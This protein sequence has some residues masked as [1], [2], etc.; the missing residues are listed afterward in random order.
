MLP[1]EQQSAVMIAALVHWPALLFT[2]AG[3]QPF[4]CSMG[5][6]TAAL[7]NSRVYAL[8]PNALQA[9]CKHCHGPTDTQWSMLAVL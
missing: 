4:R 3:V 9:K 7:L 1:P 6:S 8:Q 5:C 2:D